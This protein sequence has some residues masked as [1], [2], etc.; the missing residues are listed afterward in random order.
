MSEIDQLRGFP[1]GKK[2]EPPPASAQDVDVSRLLKRAEIMR[3][4]AGLGGQNTVLS[5][6]RR[7]DCI[8]RL[9]RL[10]Y[11]SQ[12]RF[13][14]LIQRLDDR[15][16]S[17]LI[18]PTTGGMEALRS[19]AAS[20]ATDQPG[21]DAV[22]QT[23]ELERGEIDA[24]SHDAEQ[25]LDQESIELPGAHVSRLYTIR[26]LFHSFWRMIGFGGKGV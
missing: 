25:G 26:Q 13:E 19:I 5:Y 11:I 16:T 18:P 17:P 22:E 24:S 3:V 7:V 10:G 2:S 23:L 8:E 12:P 4:I 21:G 1:K 15:L 9:W 6:T 20:G 14:S